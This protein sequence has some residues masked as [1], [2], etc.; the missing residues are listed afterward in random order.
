MPLK[1]VVWLGWRCGEGWDG[2][3]GPLVEA[4]GGHVQ[5]CRGQTLMVQGWEGGWGDEPRAPCAVPFADRNGTRPVWA[6]GESQE[7]VLYS[8]LAH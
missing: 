2:H 7:L 1:L 5:L 8:Q 4:L 6:G 3:P